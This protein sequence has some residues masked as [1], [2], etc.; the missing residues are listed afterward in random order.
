[1]TPDEEIAQALKKGA[2]IISDTDKYT[3]LE[4]PKSFSTLGFVILALFL[5]PLALL[6]L[7]MYAVSKPKILV[8]TKK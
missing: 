5:F 2:K 3:T 7:V 6:Y 8:V 4:F 1:M